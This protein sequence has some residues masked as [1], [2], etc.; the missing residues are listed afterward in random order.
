[1][2]EFTN[3]IE[4][5]IC[6]QTDDSQETEIMLT[7]EKCVYKVPQYSGTSASLSSLSSHLSQVNSSL[8]WMKVQKSTET[9]SYAISA[10]EQFSILLK[11]MI[12]QISRN[13][14]G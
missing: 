11:R 9:C 1:M 13:R 3:Q 6:Y 2:N 10:F 12:K 7:N 14:Q 4:L 8:A 5:K